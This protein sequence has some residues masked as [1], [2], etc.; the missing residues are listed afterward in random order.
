MRSLCH[1]PTDFDAVLKNALNDLRLVEFL[2]EVHAIAQ[3]LLHL[4]PL[5][6]GKYCAVV[7]FTNKDADLIGG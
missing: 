1:L 7:N 5:M 2:D 4:L 3:I 6:R